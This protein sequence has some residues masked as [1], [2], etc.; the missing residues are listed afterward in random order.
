[1][2]S[3]ALLILFLY[4]RLS[5]RPMLGA[6]LFRKGVIKYVAISELLAAKSEKESR[7]HR[8]IC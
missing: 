6:F 3:Q 4:L 5:S 2:N 8:W 7:G 1:M